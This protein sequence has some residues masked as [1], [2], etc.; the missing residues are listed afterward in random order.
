MP[1]TVRA[2]W[3]GGLMVAGVFMAL[4]PARSEVVGI[5]VCLERAPG[6][7][8]ELAVTGRL[9]GPVTRAGVRQRAV[10]LVDRPVEEWDDTPVL[11]R[12]SAVVTGDTFHIA[13]PPK[14]G[15]LCPLV[16]APPPPSLLAAP[17]TRPGAAVG[18]RTRTAAGPCVPWPHR[19]GNLVLDT[20]DA[21]L[22]QTHGLDALLGSELADGLVGWGIQGTVP[23]APEGAFVEVVSRYLH[24]APLTSNTALAP[25]EDGFFDLHWRGYPWAEPLLCRWTRDGDRVESH[26]CAPLRPP[27]DAREASF[28]FA[29][30]PFDSWGPLAEPVPVLEPGRLPPAARQRLDLAA[31]CGGG[32]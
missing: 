27:A 23:D 4:I 13:G 24:D 8:P 3:L 31:R 18:D 11:V 28:V 30:A 15:W 16:E 22:V 6:P 14:G 12:S 26:G 21:T 7:P 32:P 1:W 29:K 20:T 10:L 17:R 25:V 19:Y 9:A 5:P 2:A